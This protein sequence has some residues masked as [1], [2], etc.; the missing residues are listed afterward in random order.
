MIACLHEL[1]S[2]TKA[3]KANNAKSEWITILWFVKVVL[4][5]GTEI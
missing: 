2:V 3:Q 1:A 5:T 4:W